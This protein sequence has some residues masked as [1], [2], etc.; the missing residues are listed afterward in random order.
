MIAPAAYQSAEDFGITDTTIISMQVSVFVLAY[1]EK[2][3]KRLY[4]VIDSYLLQLLD[5]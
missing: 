5:L 3:L 1:G 4:V 2:P